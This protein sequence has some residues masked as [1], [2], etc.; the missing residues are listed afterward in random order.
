MVQC[1]WRQ[2]VKLA[3]LA[4]LGFVVYSWELFQLVISFSSSST[5]ASLSP[6]QA[7]AVHPTFAPSSLTPSA[8]SDTFS[9][10]PTTAGQPGEPV[11]QPGSLQEAGPLQGPGPS[12]PLTTTALPSHA[13]TSP[14]PGV[15]AEARLTSDPAPSPSA[16]ARLSPFCVRTCA[17]H[18]RAQIAACACPRPSSPAPPPPKPKR[19]P[20]T[21]NATYWWPKH[22]EA[23][24]G[25]E[26]DGVDSFRNA[27]RD[28][29]NWTDMPTNG[30]HGLFEG[31][32]SNDQFRYMGAL[33]RHHLNL[34][35]PPGEGVICQTGFNY[36]T[37]AYAFLC[38]TDAKRMYS[39][40]LGYHFY[41][42]EAEKTLNRD[43]VS[44]RHTLKTG[45][46]TWTLVEEVKGKGIL[47]YG[48]K[49]DVV[50]VDGG[51]TYEI[52]HLDIVN[53]AKIAVPGALFII[54]DCHYTRSHEGP[55]M[56]YFDA[57]RAGV[58][59]AD[60]TPPGLRTVFNDT[61]GGRSVCVGRYP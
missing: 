19:V 54:D 48:E 44:G 4:I 21:W 30:V 15:A 52:A 39:W 35:T 36:G 31:A 32:G 7:P 17:R 25:C 20:G 57:V 51:H 28:E 12:P 58:L 46:S 10:P 34:T 40:D 53:F 11:P 43:F 29:Y 23:T 38:H 26:P 9:P 56:A 27:L 33:A 13:M 6:S 5:A 42:R 24:E 47:R 37:S 41:T 22:D 60:M 45:S 3:A 2:L 14:K 8:P 49:C 50:F 18:P 1:T 55:S 59:A 61:P 16:T